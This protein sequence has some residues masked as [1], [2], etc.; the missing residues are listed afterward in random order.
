MPVPVGADATMK[1]AS[2]FDKHS[3]DYEAQDRSRFLFYRWVINSVV[4]E[5]DGDS[6]DVIDL[7]TGTGNL[8]IRI[9]SRWPKARVLGVDIS[10]GMIAE[11]RA[12]CRK[13]GLMNARFKVGSIEGL[14][15]GKIDFAVSSLA[16]HHVRDKQHAASVICASLVEGGKLVVGDWFRPSRRYEEEVGALRRRNPDRARKFDRSWEASLKRTSRRYREEHPKEYPVS[17]TRLAA[18]FQKAG[19]RE[20]RIL[21]SPLPNFAVVVGTK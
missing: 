20:Q 11:A 15:A 9:A 12:K 7:G 5:I 16:F 2:F 13:M 18:I 3:K 4:R 1:T 8:A 19:F 14:Q 17:Q 21:K 10:R 6:C